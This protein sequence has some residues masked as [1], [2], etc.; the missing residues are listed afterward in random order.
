MSRTTVSNFLVSKLV[1]TSKSSHIEKVGD[2]GNNG[3]GVTNVRSSFWFK[4]AKSKNMV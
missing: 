4:M 3:V 1:T 2:D